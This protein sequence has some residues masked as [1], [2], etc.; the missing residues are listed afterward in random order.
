[1]LLEMMRLT[2]TDAPFVGWLEASA[3]IGAD[4]YVSAFD[5][6]LTAAGD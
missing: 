1:M 4:A 5:R 3:P 2:Q 6:Q